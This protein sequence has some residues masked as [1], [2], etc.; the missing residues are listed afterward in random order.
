MSPTRAAFWAVLMLIVV[1]LT[2]RALV[3]CLRGEYGRCWA[4]LRRGVSDLRNGL[5]NGGLNM[6]PV[7]V[8]T[9]AA[10]IVIGS[11]TLTGVG[12]ILA[13]I[14]GVLSGGN[15]LLML[16]MV[17]CICLILGTGLTTTT[18]YLIVSSLLVPV[19]MTVGGNNGLFVPLIAAHLFVFYFGLMAD[20]LPPAGL[21]T[22]AAASIAGANAVRTGVIAFRYSLRMVILPFMFVFNSHLLL[23]DVDGFA[24]GLLVVMAATLAGFVFIS[25]NQAWLLVRS[26]GSERVLLLLATVMLFHPGLFMDRWQPAFVTVGGAAIGDA[27]MAAPDGGRVRIIMSGTTLEGRVIERAVLLPLAGRAD[28]AEARLE[29]LGLKVVALQA[30]EGEAGGYRV[31]SVGLAPSLARLGIEPGF[32]LE[33]VQLRADRIAKEWMFLPALLLIAWVWQ[34]QRRRRGGVA[35]AG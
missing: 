29:R 13:D 7:A 33:A 18:N 28:S 8:G 25:V 4:E 35:K 20:I 24:H 22:H 17:A 34:R 21:A 10:G 12:L 14:V 16:I 30:A 27:I 9:A 31:E 26:T 11:F 1:V 15:V 2:Q 6:V 32:V 3:A 23:I 5:I 19:I